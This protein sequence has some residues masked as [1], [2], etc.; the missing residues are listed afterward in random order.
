[1]E[2]RRQ[3]MKRVKTDRFHDL[4][5]LAGKQQYLL[6]DQIETFLDESASVEDMDEVYIALNDL[7]V[8]V[9]DSHEEAQQKL[10]LK[11]REE[12]RPADKQV[13]PH[14]MRYDDPV[15]M[16][17]R[18]MG[19]VPLL[20]REGEVEIA[21]RI[22]A[23]ERQVCTA[24]FRSTPIMKELIA[25][26]T[27]LKQG[28]VR[29]EEF[30]QIDFGNWN[31][32][33]SPKKERARALKSMDRVRALHGKLLKIQE[34]SVGRLSEEKRK[35]HQE[36][37]RAADEELLKELY[38]LNMNNKLIER[39]AERMKGLAKRFEEAESDVTTM[40]WNWGK[41]GE[42]V[43]ALLKRIK[44]SRKEAKQIEKET[45]LKPADLDAY[46]LEVKNARRKVRR[47]EI[48][49][50]MLR[51]QIREVATEI[52]SGEIARDK[53]KREMIEANVRLVISIAKRYT[54]RGLE[55]LDLIQEGNS[56]LMRAVDKFDYRKGYKFSTYATW[57]IRQAIT[58]AIADQ[59]RTIRVP[60]HMIEAIN[61]VVRT[62]RRLVQELGREPTPEEVAEKLTLP[63]E[64][65]K[66]VL[67][68]AQEPI[69]LDRPIGEDDDSNLG[70]FIEDT[71]VIS[72]AQAAAFSMLKDEVNEVLETLSKREAKVIRLRFG[73][74]D[75]GCPR[76]LEEVGATFN[77]TRE[78]IRQIEAKALR[79]LRHPTRSRR[80]KGYVEMM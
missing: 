62:S 46:V 56:G 35:A 70:D 52:R 53:A 74:T 32:E 58:R 19:R 27:K 77:V 79:K 60:V 69:S 16:Y 54:N 75:D 49:G 22:K 30:T 13:L 51:E 44:K 57:W 20:D 71:S 36:K 8:D 50:R 37:V 61:K 17:L 28:K 64:K 12:K 73:L 45:G 67:K 21:K 68:A 15:R 33:F 47:I 25:L 18:E 76:T 63:V 23:G 59:A 41:T 40:E 9:F 4:K 1:M 34:R 31:P 72:P 66:S 11:R 65:I 24:L 6:H 14:P 5:V 38:A 39:L 78:R 26:G 3:R 80:L 42:E 29:V 2:R 55:F 7:K 48:E 10:K 43:H